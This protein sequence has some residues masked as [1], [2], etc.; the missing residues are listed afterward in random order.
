MCAVLRFL[1]RQSGCLSDTHVRRVRPEQE[2]AGQPAASG[3]TEPAGGLGPRPSVPSGPQMPGAAGVWRNTVWLQCC[4]VWRNTVRLPGS[5][6]GVGCGGCS[7]AC[8]WPA[9]P[10]APLRQDCPQSGV[11]RSARPP[12]GLLPASSWPVA[13]RPQTLPP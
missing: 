5:H 12:P 8:R 1:H 11:Q 7:Q 6:P 3:G 13:N 9:A 2:A 10:P 4:G